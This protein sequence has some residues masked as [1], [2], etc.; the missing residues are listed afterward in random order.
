MTCRTQAS[1]WPSLL[2]AA[3]LLVLV[4]GV[5]ALAFNNRSDDATAT[6]RSPVAGFHDVESTI[7][8]WD[9]LVASSAAGS[10]SAAGLLP[11][12]VCA[13]PGE[14]CRQSTCCQLIGE[15]CYQMTDTYATCN[16]TCRGTADQQLIC[17]KLGERACPRC[18]T[19]TNAQRPDVVVPTFER[20]LEKTIIL[21]WSLVKNDPKC[22]LGDV[23][24]LWVSK[25]QPWQFQ[26]QLDQISQVLGSTC[27]R[28]LKVKD[29]SGAFQAEQ[30]R[31]VVYNFNGE[32]CVI[33]LSGWIAQQSLK[34]KIAS[35]L[36]SDFYVVLDSKNAL[37][38]EVNEDTFF[39]SCNQAKVFGSYLYDAMP[40]PHRDW[41]QAASHF[42]KID[43]N[44]PSDMYWPTSITPAVLHRQT[45]LDLL[46]HIGECEDPYRICCGM[47]CDYLGQ[48]STEFTMYYIFA[49]SK[50]DKDCI[51]TFQ[52]PSQRREEPTVALWRVTQDQNLR[53]CQK[54][55][56]GKVK[57]LTF[58]LQ[59]GCLSNGSA[60]SKL[61][62]C[63]FNVYAAAGLAKSSW[64]TQEREDFIMKVA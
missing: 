9:T 52:A 25:N 22:L 46:D 35:L 50:A 13:A 40:A 53:W 51:H 57:T 32:G 56:S 7:G 59:S 38:S 28:K 58:G 2:K 36:K 3:L 5:L 60:H 17:N 4:L 6:H 27:G 1:R 16:A 63:V 42:L 21:A 55:S 34:L 44:S 49:F 11:Q 47:M 61:G 8:R 64:S 12:T 24:L 26:A 15:Q 62:E 45:A 31:C 18:N 23:T 30:S 43:V 14:D 20:D 41:Y 19:S 33:F 39:S 29:F 48:R 37:V 10:S 54:V